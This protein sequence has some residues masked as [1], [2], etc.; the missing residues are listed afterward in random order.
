MIY[1]ADAIANMIAH[2]YGFK[3]QFSVV[4]LNKHES[5]K[6]SF[7]DFLDYNISGKLH[8]FL[9][10]KFPVKT[11]NVDF[12]E[13][14]ILNREFKG[15]NCQIGIVLKDPDG[16][17][18]YSYNKRP[19]IQIYYQQRIISEFFVESPRD[20]DKRICDISNYIPDFKS[21]VRNAK[22]DMLIW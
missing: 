18:Y 17:S 6:D 7:Y 9:T 2:S 5:R 3:E 21:D 10:R 8:S 19:Y 15:G 12:E 1:I 22:L 14:R 11:K 20:L 13:C 16:D 4:P